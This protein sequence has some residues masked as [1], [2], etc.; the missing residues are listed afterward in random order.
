MKHLLFLGILSCLYLASCQ[1]STPEKGKTTDPNKSNSGKTKGPTPTEI[2]AAKTEKDGP[3]EFEFIKIVIRDGASRKP[4]FE[5]LQ[6]IKG[7]D[8]RGYYSIASHNAIKDKFNNHDVLLM[9]VDSL[10]TRY[11]HL[12]SISNEDE[13]SYAEAIRANTT[14]PKIGIYFITKEEFFSS[15]I[16]GIGDVIYFRFGI[17]EDKTTPSLWITDELYKPKT[18]G[19]IDPDPDGGPLNGIGG[20]RYPKKK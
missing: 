20:I 12:V 19:G 16:K 11:A 7:S 18:L 6:R 2:I 10:G 9:R 4:E 14:N 8:D 15:G 1:N 3:R 13:D 17:L 5:N